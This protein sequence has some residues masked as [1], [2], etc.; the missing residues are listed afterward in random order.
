MTP[1]S[2]RGAPP[3]PRL[4]AASVRLAWEAGR[5][6][7][8]V[9]IAT[10]VASI[11]LIAA[12]V[13]V[14][15]SLVSSLLHAERSSGGVGS[16]VPKVLVLAAL[17]A[18]LGIATAVQLHRQR[19]LSELCTRHAEDRVLAVTGSVELAA[20]DE[21]G[22]HDSVERA[23]LAARRLPAVITSLSGLLRALA[24]AAGAVIGLA[25]LQPLFA[26]FVLLVLIP[27]WLA[28]RRRGRVFH[29]F[30]RAITPRDR[31]RRYL[32]ELLAD[33]DAAKEVRAY[34]LPRFLGSRRGE[35]W[36]ERLGR[37]RDV[38]GRQ[39]AVTV[40]ADLAAAAIVAAT[41]VVLIALTLSHDIGLAGAGVTAATIV[42]LG[43]R[44]TVAATNAG[45]LSES[46]LFIDDYLALVATAPPEA[47][48][49]PRPPDPAQPPRPL[50]VEAEH[51]SFSYAG[52]RG[53][54]LSDVSLEIEPGEV[55]A[56][57]GENGSGK[58]TLAKVL[59]G[60]YAPGAG[61]V[62]WNG[63]DAAG[64]H[65]DGRC[66]QV[67]VIFQDFMRYALPARENIGLGRPESM[68]HDD[69]G[70]RRAARSAG[71]HEDI[72]RLPD[73][74][75]TM[76]G[77][78]FAG[79]TDLSIGQWQRVAL[80][81]ALFRDAP[82]VILDEPTAALDAQA[83]HRLFAGIRKLLAGRSVLLISHRFSSVREADRIH[84]MHAGSIVESGKHDELMTRRGRYA[85]LFELQAA[86]YR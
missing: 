40:L 4:V 73:G 1:D 14:A 17:T 79:G 24:G 76:L 51:V 10:Q 82:F 13:L 57:V 22:F 21:P 43:Q 68:G 83:E 50:R 67:A 12:E 7:L 61:R 3:L 48:A 46:A 58:T 32:T 27:T 33:R 85:E 47:E 55:V 28:A 56:L 72:E 54:A 19:I 74:Y 36:D 65:R 70:V 60:L 18:A 23:L 30:A 59:A 81:R 66:G 6:E 75:D 39:L 2:R 77:S 62:T 80:A 35:L 69:E 5:P 84:V 45:G 42:L 37:L 52:A 41:L 49:G 64:S 25:A 31:E 26:P 16:L 86:P 9:I 63:V 44:L 11:V 15:R 78:E 38:A 34:G 53:P 8:T 71:A 20:F 29:R